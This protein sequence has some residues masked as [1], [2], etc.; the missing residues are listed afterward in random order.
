MVYYTQNN[1]LMSLVR[2][3]NLV[4]ICYKSGN[5]KYREIWIYYTSVKKVAT[6]LPCINSNFPEF[7]ITVFI[8]DYH[9]LGWIP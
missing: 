4:I 1:I 6:F 9:K 3:V 7:I 5:N 8:T 2:L